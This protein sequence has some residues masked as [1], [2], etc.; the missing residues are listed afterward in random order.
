MSGQT[1]TGA[2]EKPQEKTC[3]S[4]YSPLPSPFSQST[5]VIGYSTYDLPSMLA[6]IGLRN[7]KL[8]VTDVSYLR[9][10]IGCAQ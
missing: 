6:C 5:Q 1:E 8:D 10:M 7:R 2:E 3:P 9:A 4:C